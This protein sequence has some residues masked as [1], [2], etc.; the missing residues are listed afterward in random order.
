M[1]RKFGDAPPDEV[2]AGEHPGPPAAEDHD[3]DL[4]GD[5]VAGEVGVRPGVP[6]EMVLAERLVLGQPLVPQPLGAF[7]LVA[8]LGRF[9]R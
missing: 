6:V 2:D 7:G 5:R 8:G 4:L 3:V 9:D 1:I